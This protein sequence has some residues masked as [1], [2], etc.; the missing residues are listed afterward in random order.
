MH[1]LLVEDNHF[2]NHYVTTLLESSNYVV[3]S[4]MSALSA[5]QYAKEFHIDIAIIDLCLPDMDGLQLVSKLRKQRLS[6]PIMMLTACNTWQNKVDGLEAGAD[7]YLVKPFQKDE[8]FARLHA[9]LR[10]STFIRASKL[11]AGDYVLDLARKELSAAGE[12][13]ALTSFEYLTLECLMRNS[14]QIISK[15]QLLSQLYSDK[16]Y[17]DLNIVEVMVSRL[18]K[19]LIRHSTTSPIVTIRNQGYMFT[20]PCYL[21]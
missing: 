10:R 8:L 19:K 16:D 17:G 2:Y 13:I 12:I 4:T 5:L 15:Q 20:L 21:T 3:Y 18:R 1:I 11:T 9:L 7:D 6:F 14:R